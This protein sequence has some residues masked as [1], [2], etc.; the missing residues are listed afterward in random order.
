MQIKLKCD[1]S[2][3]DMALRCAKRFIAEHPDRVGFNHGCVYSNDADGM[4]VYRT[5]YDMIVAKQIVKEV[6][7][8]A[9]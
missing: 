5:V 8:D 2:N 1:E 6:K 4:Y 9:E 7:T 3:L